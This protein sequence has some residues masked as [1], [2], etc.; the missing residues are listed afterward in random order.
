MVLASWMT[1]RWRVEAQTRARSFI[2]AFL[3][4]MVELPLV[5]DGVI[6]A[7]AEDFFG[8][9]PYRLD[10]RKCTHILQTYTGLE[11]SCAHGMGRVVGVI[12]AAARKYLVCQACCGL[13]RGLLR[14]VASWLDARFDDL[15][16]FNDNV[17][18]AV[19]TRPEGSKRRRHGREI[20]EF[21]KENVLKKRKC[22]A[23]TAA[24]SL[25]NS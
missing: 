3:A 17:L 7:L 21:I 1:I 6:A 23:Q 4:K 5:S 15:E 19:E 16:C 2:L 11:D 12:Q 18:H 24:A 25:E 22:Q 10:G 20:R 8:A 13:L 14:R 9:C